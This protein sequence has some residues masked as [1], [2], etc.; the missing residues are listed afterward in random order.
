MR[1]STTSTRAKHSYLVLFAI[2][3]SVGCAAQTG[4]PIVAQSQTNSKS[5]K[6]PKNGPQN[7]AEQKSAYAGLG[8]WRSYQKSAASKFSVVRTR[9]LDNAGRPLTA[10]VAIDSLRRI[11]VN[12]ERNST[13]H[14]TFQIDATKNPTLALPVKEAARPQPIGNHAVHTIFAEGHWYRIF[15]DGFF[16][17]ALRGAERIE[18]QTQKSLW[19]KPNEIPQSLLQRAEFADLAGIPWQKVDEERTSYWEGALDQP[20]HLGPLLIKNGEGEVQQSAA[21]PDDRFVAFDNSARLAV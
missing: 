4:T 3:A 21:L 19:L 9:V 7:T 14:R 17:F 13:G 16:P 11:L 6:P 5:G 15:R 10:S 8:W 12:S 2:A 1:N 18:V 20:A